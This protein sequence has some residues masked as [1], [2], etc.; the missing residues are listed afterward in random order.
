MPEIPDG[1]P[2]LSVGC[3]EPGEGKACIMEYVSVL[4]G[5]KFNHLP[6]CTNPM[7]ARLAW[8][9][10][11][12]CSEDQRPRLFAFAHRLAAATETNTDRVNR[13]LA[14]FIDA[15]GT[16]ASKM[17]WVMLTTRPYETKASADVGI[18]LLDE[19]LTA[20]EKATGREVP[21]PVKS[22]A[23]NRAKELIETRSLNV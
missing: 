22:E 11:D 1:L 15:E 17:R 2:S 8:A 3:H 13:A 12:L 18:K 20:H 21:E 14:S 9:V 5:E 19:V 16:L 23:L 6:A 7:I 4:A 10:N